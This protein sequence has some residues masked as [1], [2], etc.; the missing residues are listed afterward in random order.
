MSEQSP[1]NGEAIYT[2]QGRMVTDHW[3]RMG[4]TY[5]VAIQ[6]LQAAGIDLEN[7]AVEDLHSMDMNHMGGLG[8]TDALGDMVKV[9]PE[10][11][12]LDVGSGV[13]GPARRIASR[14]GASVWGIELSEPLCQTAV[15]LTKLVG[16]QEQVQ[17]KHASALDLPFPAD[18]FDVVI[19]QHVAMQISEKEQLFDECARVIKPRGCLAMH[20]I[21]SGN[22]EPLTY[23][24]A[25]ASEPA[26]S[27]LEPF[28]LCSERL[29]RLGFQVGQFVDLSEEGRQ[30]HQLNFEAAE[31][32]L[33]KSEGEGA[34]EILERRMRASRAMEKNIRIGAIRV[35]MVVSR[36]I[37]H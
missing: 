11:L 14:Y 15:R 35:G 5:E 12:V 21:F 8:A 19:L 17:F 1:P 2:Q 29:S 10:Q 6:R 31:A 32:A 34:V 20:E 3:A 7:V 23:P 30:Y 24:L 28:E 22:D 36:K 13:G 16:L 37:E 9:G 26:M 4:I 33:A 18:N 25:W 27:S